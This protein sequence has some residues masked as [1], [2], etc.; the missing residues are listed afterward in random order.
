MRFSQGSYN[1]GTCLDCRC[2]VKAITRPLLRG[3][4]RKRCDIGRGQDQRSEG[5]T[6]PALKT[7]EGAV[8]QGRQVA[9]GSWKGPGN[10]FPLAF[11]KDCSP[12]DTWVLAK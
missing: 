9:S 10:R 4:Q 11:P 1:E 7:E 3:K 8:S 5:T 6:V 12:A 2:G